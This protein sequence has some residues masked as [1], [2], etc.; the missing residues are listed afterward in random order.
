LITQKEINGVLVVNKPKGPT[1]HTVVVQAR[2]A[3]KVKAGHTGTLDP[4]ATGVLPVL[5]GKATRLA[6]FYQDSE[7]EY[8]AVIR[9][10][11]ETDTYDADGAIIKEAP[12]PHLSDQELLD[13]LQQFHGK[14]KQ[15]PPI[16]SA[17][18]VSGKRLYQSARNSEQVERPVRDVEFFRIQLLE[19]S[20]DCFTIE[21][22]CSS[23]T[24]IRSLAFDVGRIIGSGA[25]LSELVRTRS[26]PF[27]LDH[28]MSLE[29]LEEQWEESFTPI[30][31]LLTEIPT[32]EL[33]PDEALRVI[34]GNPI[35]CDP[36]IVGTKRLFF[37]SQ[38][39]AIGESGAGIIQPNIVLRTVF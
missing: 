20:E 35:Y 11:I 10:G 26:G 9:L 33:S 14:R 32:L 13:I 19:R 31:E 5:L 7:K 12:V 24:Y 23:G 16:Y 6:R 22:H 17:I 34:H 4:M 39:I 30:E 1:S 18:K 25:H 37:N 29:N 27:H 38:L 36:S 15:V 2:K 28:S 8:R 3:L 21:V